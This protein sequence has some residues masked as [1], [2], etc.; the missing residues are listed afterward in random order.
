MCGGRCAVVVAQARINRRVG[1]VGRVQG[2]GTVRAQ[3]R[4]SVGRVRSGGGKYAHTWAGVRCGRC[5][6]IVMSGRW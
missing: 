3:E 1:V 2:C 4:I 5:A 6:G